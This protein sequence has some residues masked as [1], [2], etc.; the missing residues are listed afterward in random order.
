[1]IIGLIPFSSPLP[2][3]SVNV[4]V[5]ENTPIRPRTVTEIARLIV[6]GG[7]IRLHGPAGKAMHKAVIE[8]VQAK[9]P[10]ST[11]IQMDGTTLGDSTTITTIIR[12]TD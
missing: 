9:Y 8:A 2:D 3:Q 1:M 11:A 5:L 12:V 4:I 10:R 7:E 6:P